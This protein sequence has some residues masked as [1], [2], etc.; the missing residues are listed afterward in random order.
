MT[1]SESILGDATLTPF[2]PKL[3]SNGQLYLP[4]VY[5]FPIGIGNNVSENS[6]LVR[7][8][9]KV[10]EK[11]KPMGTIG[12]IFYQEEEIYFV[13]GALV[14]SENGKILFFPGGIDR[15]MTLSPEGN[16][17]L[18]QGVLQ[19]ID[20]LSLESNYRNYHVTLLEKSNTNSPK[21][22]RMNTYRVKEDMFFGSQWASGTYPFLNLHPEIR[23]KGRT[24]NELKRK[25]SFIDKSRGD[26]IFN[27]VFVD[28][29]PQERYVINFE[30]YVSLRK[31]REYTQ[32]E[33]ICHTGLVPVT[34]FKEQRK[35]VMARVHPVLLKGF[36]GML[37]VRVSKIVG[38]HDDDSV[39]INYP[40]PS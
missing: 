4:L 36:S 35:K 31:S 9:K 15:R 39:F 10:L 8:F 32:P 1:W 2:P 12:Y 38:T 23:I 25:Y 24:P 11:G 13:F 21:Y 17:I 37:R 3:D 5:S 19:N 7:P 27:A 33:N 18:R 14:Y 6:A 26:C 29:K 16:E 20:H 34:Q 30:F 22:P 40:P 28:D